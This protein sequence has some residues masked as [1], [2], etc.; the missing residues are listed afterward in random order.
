MTYYMSKIHILQDKE[1]V[2]YTNQ[3]NFNSPLAVPWF[4]ALPR[5]RIVCMILFNLTEFLI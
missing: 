4:R 1:K 2:I 5:E 3:S